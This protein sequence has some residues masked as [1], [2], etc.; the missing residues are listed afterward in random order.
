MRIPR[1]RIVALVIVVIIAAG[2]LWL[3]IPLHPS[4]R[5]DKLSG[6]AYMAGV[7][8]MNILW[9]RPFS[10][11]IA[12]LPGDAAAVGAVPFFIRPL[13]PPVMEFYLQSS[14]DGGGWAIVTDLGWRSKVF[15]M[16]HRVIIGQMQYRGIGAIEG[17]YVLRTPSGTRLLFYQDGRTLFIAEGENIIGKIAGNGSLTKNADRADLQDIASGTQDKRVMANMSFSNIDGDV[18]KGIEMLEGKAGFMLLP[19][20]GSLIK[21]SMDI[22]KTGRSTIAG[23]ITLLV[24]E[25]GDIEGVEGDATYLADL[26]D[27][28]LSGQNM[29]TDRTINRENSKIT[30]Q[31]MI[32]P[33]GEKL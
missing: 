28:F 10:S 20:A 8:R 17:E 5:K 3:L 29:K 22:R 7:V 19:S 23:V 14:K 1:F 6:Q 11:I 15:G 27:R 21:G 2:V 32:H 31:I 30:I 12:S 25:D 13:I 16:L 4:A 24:R 18:T 26:L 33:D 9:E